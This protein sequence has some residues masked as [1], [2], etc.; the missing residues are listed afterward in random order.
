MSTTTTNFGFV[1]PELTDPADI[2]SF[3][4]NWDIIDENL[5][6]AS[7]SKA[8]SVV[9][10]ATLL[11]GN[12]SGSG[13]Y[14]WVNENITSA[15]QII[16]LLPSET[17]TLEQLEALQTANIVGNAQE[18]GNVTFKAYGDIP[19]VDI[20]VVFIIRGDV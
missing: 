16:E 19:K 9:V 14:T 2:T 4:A 13:I 1:K 11:A 8:T 7:E 6:A 18:V 10:E 17:I 15:D 3:N 12:W 20:P 5:K